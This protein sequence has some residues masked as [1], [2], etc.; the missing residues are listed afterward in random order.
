[1][2]FMESPGLSKSECQ[3]LRKAMLAYTNNGA[4]KAFFANTGYGDMGKITDQ[5][6]GRL[7]SF[8]AELNAKTQLR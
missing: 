2:I 7:S 4:G 8:I 1:M 6:M 3:Q 5:D